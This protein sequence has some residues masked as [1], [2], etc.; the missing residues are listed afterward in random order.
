MLKGVRLVSLDVTNTLIGLRE[1][2]GQTY[3]RIGAKHELKLDADLIQERFP[4]A[5]KRLELQKPAFDYAGS[6]SVRWWRDL[7]DEVCVEDKDNVNFGRFYVD[8][9]RHYYIDAAAW[10]ILDEKIFSYFDRFHSLGLKV[11]VISNFDMRLRTIL[12]HLKLLDRVDYLVLSGEVGVQKPDGKIL[13]I[14]QE[15]SGIQRKDEIVHIGDNV[16]K[17]YKAALDYG[18]RAILYDPKKK[19]EDWKEIQRISSFEEMF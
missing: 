5:F 2:P 15:K 16:E 4:A 9:Y 3:Q 1:S 6:G 17:D 8:L 10:R 14:L 12:R 7:L 13:E 19:F 18:I 11:G